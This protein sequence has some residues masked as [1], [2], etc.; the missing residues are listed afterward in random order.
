M[1]KVGHVAGGW[2]SW[3]VFDDEVAPGYASAYSRDNWL[4]YFPDS[5][6]KKI[7]EKEADRLRQLRWQGKLVT[8]RG[9]P[10]DGL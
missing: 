6:S 1:I 5:L 9:N 4:I 2:D 3:V 10:D 8:N 7:A